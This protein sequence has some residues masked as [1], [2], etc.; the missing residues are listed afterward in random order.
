V[1]GAGAPS[2]EE[3]A[4][5]LADALESRGTDY[6]IG[7]ALALA[8]WGVVRGTL[9]VDLNLWVDP[10]KP[11]EAA[12]VLAELGCEF[13]GAAVIREFAGRGCAYVSKRGVHVDVYLPTGEFHESVRQRRRR[14]PLCGRDAWFL[15]AED[16]AVF[17]MLLFR[18]KE[19]GDV[20]ALLVV[21]GRD[22]ERPYA[23][24]WLA[25][26]VGPSDHRVKTWDEMVEQAEAAL[27]LR[28][29]AWRPPL[30]T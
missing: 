18:T 30:E 9:D 19:G 24:G 1:S 11:T 2:A 5:E 15:S 8:Q 29:S 4:R 20:E 28:E 6:A 13:K 22:F 14:R 27:R 3:V 7:G 26:A 16:L 10:G 21:C 12:Q 23:R 25:G 17:K